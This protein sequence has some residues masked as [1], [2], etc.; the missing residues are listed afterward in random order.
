[1]S[2][3]KY[4]SVL[5]STSRELLWQVIT[6]LFFKR[7]FVSSNKTKQKESVKKDIETSGVNNKKKIPSEVWLLVLQLIYDQNNTFVNH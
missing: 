5:L 6:I 2:I 1:M 7:R 4:F 3:M